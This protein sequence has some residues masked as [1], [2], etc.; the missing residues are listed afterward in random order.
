MAT[1][2]YSIALE[3]EGKIGKALA[4]EVRMSPKWALEICSEL[5]GKDFAKAIEFLEDVRHM[6]RPL[7]LKRYKKGVAHRKGLQGAYAGRYP[8]KAASKMIK[9]LESARANAEYK[10]LDAERLYIKHVSAQ[11]GRV[12]RGFLPRAHGRAT[13]KNEATANIQV[14]LEER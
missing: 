7:P 1:T 12:I 6:K 4:R 5:R 10:G 13:P 3:E 11:R 14:V 9:I 8:V 2:G